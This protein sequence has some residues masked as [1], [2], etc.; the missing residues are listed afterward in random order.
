[1]RV[2]IAVEIPVERIVEHSEETFEESWVESHVEREIERKAE[3]KAQGFLRGFLCVRKIVLLFQ[4]NH[5]DQPPQVSSVERGINTSAVRGEFAS[6]E[7]R[8]KS[9]EKAGAIIDSAWFVCS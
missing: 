5:H 6:D 8:E 2:E 9:R 7:S 4:S 1:M 3:P